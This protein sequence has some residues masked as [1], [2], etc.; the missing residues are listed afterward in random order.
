ML[1]SSSHTSPTP[2]VDLVGLK[3]KPSRSDNG[4][5]YFPCS[6]HKVRNL[7]SSSAVMYECCGFPDIM[8]SFN[9]YPRFPATS[10]F[11][12]SVL[13]NAL[14]LLDSHLTLQ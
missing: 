8:L 11:L 2:A 4:I 14:S 10:I 1:F 5:Y 7:G 9:S 6:K 3:L 12:Q 13:L